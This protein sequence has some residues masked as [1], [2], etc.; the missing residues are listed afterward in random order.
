M[1]WRE[2]LEANHTFAA[3]GLSYWTTGRYEQLA[4][5]VF[6]NVEWP[7]R[8]YIEHAHGG[9]AKTLRRLP[10]KNLTGA[11]CRETRMAFLL[12]RKA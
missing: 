10:L 12:T 8:F 7:M 6:G 4:R 9:V 1:T 11:L 5:E 2:V 3:E